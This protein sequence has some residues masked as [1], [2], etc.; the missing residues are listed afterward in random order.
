MKVADLDIIEPEPVPHE[1]SIFKQ[2][3]LGY[4]DAPGLAQFQHTV[5]RPGQTV[6]PHA[7][8]DKTEIFFGL[9]G[10]GEVV[11]GGTPIPFRRG[12]CVRVDPGEIHALCNP[13][14]A[15]LEFLVL[16]LA[17]TAGNRRPA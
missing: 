6:N 7:H 16:G 10:A 15:L 4:G 14:P 12:L 2:V 5:L 11:V 3:L 13:G 8:L 9:S 1:P 17:P